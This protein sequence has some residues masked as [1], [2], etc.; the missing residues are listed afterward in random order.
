[1]SAEILAFQFLT[2]RPSLQ[3]GHENVDI[4]TSWTVSG[5]VTSE[6][7][8]ACNSRSIFGSLNI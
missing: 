6:L 3:I 8:W 1:M 7:H 5:L 2:L 4:D